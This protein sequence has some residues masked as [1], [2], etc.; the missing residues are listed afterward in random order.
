MSAIQNNQLKH[1]CDNCEQDIEEF[2][3]CFCKKCEEIAQQ[4]GYDMGYEYAHTE[5]NG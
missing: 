1:I 5:T 2:K 4:R 3:S